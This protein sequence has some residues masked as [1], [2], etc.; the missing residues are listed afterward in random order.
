MPAGAS[1]S[2]MEHAQRSDPGGAFYREED[3]HRLAD[4]VTPKYARFT[5]R[6]EVL[7]WGPAAWVLFV[8]LA[9]GLEQSRV[10]LEKRDTE[11]VW[12]RFHRN[13]NI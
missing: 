8:G 6:Q 10:L 12:T 4:N 1:P 13:P 9:L 11:S 7:L 3:L 5:V 2:L